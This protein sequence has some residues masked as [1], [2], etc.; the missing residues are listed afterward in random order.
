MNEQELARGFIMKYTLDNNGLP[1]GWLDLKPSF[2]DS[3][4]VGNVSELWNAWHEEGVYAITKNKHHSD[5]CRASW[6][7]ADV[8][9]FSR[10]CFII[11]HILCKADGNWD[12]IPRTL[13]E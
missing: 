7:P 12:N 6:K 4:Y 5:K 10:L 13:Q 11:D 8:K 9:Q 3:K 1:C 2:M